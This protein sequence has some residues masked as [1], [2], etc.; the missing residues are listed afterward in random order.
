VE[1]I[2]VHNVVFRL[3]IV[4]EIFTIKV[5]SCPKSRSLM[6]RCTYLDEILQEHISSQS[7]N[8]HTI[9]RS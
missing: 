1:K 9:S 7:P 6:N 3:S 2:V 4:P 5:Y 8:T